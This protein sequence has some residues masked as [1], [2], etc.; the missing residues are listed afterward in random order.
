MKRYWRHKVF[1]N[2]HLWFALVP[3]LDGWT[4]YEYASWCQAFA[5]AQYKHHTTNKE[6]A[7]AF[8]RRKMNPEQLTTELRQLVHSL[9]AQAK[10]NYP[11]LDIAVDME[12]ALDRL[13]NKLAPMMPPF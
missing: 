2:G 9:R 5:Q 1:K 12:E 7:V 10:D 4:A 8:L 6:D 13:E 11:I 3:S